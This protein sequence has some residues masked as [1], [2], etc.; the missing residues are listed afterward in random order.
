MSKSQ[1]LLNT[2]SQIS[3]WI[4]QDLKLPKKLTDA[5]EV[6]SHREGVTLFITLLTAFKV[7]LYRYTGQEEVVVCSPI[8]NRNYPKVEG[9]IENVTNTLAVRTY[10]GDNP[11]F[12]ELLARVHEVV[13]GAYGHPELSIE[14]I[15]EGLQLEQDGRRIAQFQVMFNFQNALRP[16]LEL[17]NQNLTSVQFINSVAYNLSLSLVKSQQEL[18]GFL[19][20]NP[21]L[22]DAATIGRMIGHLQTL[23]DSV[24]ADPQQ[25]LTDL[26]LLTVAEQHQLLIEWNDTKTDYPHDKC[27]HQLFEEQVE[28]TPNALAT[29]F[30]D[31]HL[32]YQQ[33]SQKANQLANY[34][35]KLGV[36]PE[37]LVGICV[38]RSLEMMVGILGILKAGGA[39]VPLDP[40]YPQERLAFM[41]K[42]MQASVLLT[43]QHLV[44]HLPP[45]QAK[46][47][48]LDTDWNVIAAESKTLPLSS[49]RP[50][51]LVYAM[52]T[53]G[54]TG[55]P[56]GV[57]VQHQGLCS[58]ILT[59]VAA[60][61]INHNDKVLQFASFSFDVSVWEI[62]SALISGATLYLIDRETMLSDQQLLQLIRNQQMTTVFLLPS[63]L[64]R[65]P[66][67]N[68]PKL[69]RVITG[70]EGFSQDFITRWAKGRHF[71][72]VYGP[73]EVTILQSFIDCSEVCPQKPL[74][75]RSMANFQYY[76]L[77][78]NLKPVP[79]GVSGELHIGGVGLARGYLNQPELNAQKFIPNPFSQE[80]GGRLYKT[81]DLVRYQSDG[82]LEFLG[83]SDH[84]LKIRGFRIE[85]GEIEVALAQHPQVRE[86]VL[87]GREDIPGDKRLVAY[88]VPVS[89]QA[90]NINQLQDFLRQKLPE[91]MMPSAFVMLDELPLMPNKKVNRQA[92]PA[93]TQARPEL[94]EPYVAPCT[95]IEELL[96]EIWGE[97]LNLEKVGIHDDFFE[98]GG[99]SLLASQVIARMCEAFEMEI[100]ARTLFESPTIADIAAV[101]TKN[102]GQKN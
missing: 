8:A 34:L 36:G 60:F 6:L 91:Y 22:I 95:S 86:T 94:D 81:G 80:E 65:L 43:Q 28:R 96:A 56:K 84:Q 90:V 85:L 92:L 40:E 54:S 10:L 3:L 57:L 70:G 7:L 32:T 35:Q 23:L 51:N 59:S 63:V 62:F 67:Q 97:I 66:S 53:S 89:K 50:N 77:D 29:V 69:G 39:Y 99:H 25:S 55:K 45:H 82:N 12:R 14:N 79:I 20:Y 27:I 58:V 98:L 2:F 19:E 38:E 61:G 37:V 42:D 4:K 73:T 44:E 49:V 87:M 13:Q 75:G 68:L 47:I 88:V 1:S 5:I 101:I 24:V 30:Q 48:C 83:R 9:L 102:Q 21:E 46:V 71:F 93:P 78:P 33:L 72:Y 100:P 17:L 52:Y 74:L 16:V 26:P 41:L 76:V 31:Q 18:I 11:S 15:V 64:K